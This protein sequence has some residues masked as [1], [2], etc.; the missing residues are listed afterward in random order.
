MPARDTVAM[1]AL[2]RGAA[3][4]RRGGCWHNGPVCVPATAAGVWTRGNPVRF[5]DWPATVCRALAASRIS[6]PIQGVHLRQQGCAQHVCFFPSKASRA[7]GP[8]FEPWGS[9]AMRRLDLLAGLTALGA[10]LYLASVTLAAL[11]LDVGSAA[12]PLQA[13]AP[14]YPRTIE[15]PDGSSFTLGRAPQRIVAASARLIDFCAVLV[16]PERI[17][18]YPEQALEYTT[19][20]EREAE[21]AGRPRFDKYAAEPLMQLEPDLVL[22]DPWQSA[23]TRTRLQEAG[24][25]VLVVPSADTWPEMRQRLLL[26]GR[27]LGEEQ[28][29]EAEAASLDARVARLAERRA[30]RRALRVV[31]YANFGSQGFSAGA[32]TTIHEAI[33]LAGLRNALADDGVS[34]HVQLTYE[35]LILLDP[36]AILV[37]LPLRAPAGHTGDRGGAG[38]ELLRSER[39]TAHLFAV[40]EGRFLRLPAGLYASGSHG[41]VRA[42]EVLAEQAESLPAAERPAEAGQAGP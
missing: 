38:E 40:R 24:V 34:G 4:A 41:I 3:L 14:G 36:D 8:F 1:D 15:L 17:A 33:V 25:P 13:P 29:A 21:L 6:R 20:G 5:R 39:A 26:L 23:D 31:P 28:R 7:L 35:Q 12:R 2:G 37:S 11:R 18:G 16:E 30:R 42:A 9:S 22:A 19:L 10:L 32:G 27:V